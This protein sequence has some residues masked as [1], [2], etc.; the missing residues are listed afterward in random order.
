MT[1]MHPAN[2]AIHRIAFHALR[3]IAPAALLT[4][5]AMPAAAR[6]PAAPPSYE[7]YYQHWIKNRTDET[8]EN[9]K[10]YIPVPQGSAYQQISDFQIELWGQPFKTT[11]EHDR[12]DQP[13]AHIWIPQIK[14][15]Q[16]LEVGYSCDVTL[17]HVDRIELRREQVGTLN[18]IP[19]EVRLKYTE[20]IESIYGLNDADVQRLAGQ[21][22]KQHPNLVDRVL[23]IHDFVARE[24]KYQRSSGWDAAPTVLRRKNG[25][26]SEFTFAFCALCRATGLP[27][28]MVG[29]SRCRQEPSPLYRD[30]M[31]H[32]WAEVYLPPYGW[33]PFDPTLDR[34]KPPKRQH[35]GAHSPDVLIVSRGGGGGHLGMQYV[36]ANSHYRL[37]ERKRAF[38]WS[39]GARAAYTEADQHHRKG[40]Y[41]ETCNAFEK[42][43]CDFPG[44]KWAKLAEARLEQMAAN[45]ETI[46][47]IQKAKATKRCKNWLEMARSLAKVG[48]IAGARRY[49]QRVLDECTESPHAEAAGHEVQTLP[50]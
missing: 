48:D 9:V 18:D 44:T 30:T 11:I 39:R 31:C 33:V 6:A 3:L 42:I 21:F 47:A 37:L 40:E 46:A 14:P 24:I 5:V 26:C 38:A 29:G 13:L 36:G 12:F 25:S 43:I 28:R 2:V 22:E 45:P 32:R 35:V 41:P 7:I 49:Y 1:V 20:N 19:P 8:L 34:G 16:A 4:S 27:T 15:G 50:R 23:E 10:V 17:N